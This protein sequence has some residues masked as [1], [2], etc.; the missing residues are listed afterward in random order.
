[1]RRPHKAEKYLKKHLIAT[2]NQKEITL[3]KEFAVWR[4]PFIICLVF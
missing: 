4:I 3:R 1:M 2:E